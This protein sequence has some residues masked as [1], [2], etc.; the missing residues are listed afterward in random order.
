MKVLKNVSLLAY[1]LTDFRH[2]FRHTSLRDDL[3]LVIIKGEGD[4]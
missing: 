2:D 4:W 1:V 3:T